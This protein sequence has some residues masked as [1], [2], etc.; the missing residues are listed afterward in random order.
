LRDDKGKVVRTLA[1]HRQGLRVLALGPGDVLLATGGEENQ[2]NL[3]DV[4]SGERL[5]PPGHGHGPPVPRGAD[6]DGR[7]HFFA[8]FFFLAG[9]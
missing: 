6:L 5:G 8:F 3:V 7:P 2:V 4:K 1:K 9:F